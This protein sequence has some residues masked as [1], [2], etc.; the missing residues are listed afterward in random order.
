MPTP[1]SRGQEMPAIS[2]LRERK[3]TLSTNCRGLITV[4]YMHAWHSV[5]PFGLPAVTRETP[6]EGRARYVGDGPVPLPDLEHRFS[7]L[8]GLVLVLL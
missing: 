7:C 6:S 5:L 1:L 8:S 3:P 2:S 4:L